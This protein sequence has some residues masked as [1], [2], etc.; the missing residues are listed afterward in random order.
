MRVQPGKQKL[1]VYSKYGGLIQGTA[2]IQEVGKAREAKS[3][4]IP[5]IK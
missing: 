4:K 1:F 5:L 2:G 3:R